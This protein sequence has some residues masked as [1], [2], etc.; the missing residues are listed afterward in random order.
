MKKVLMVV[1]SV[2]AAL[3][4]MIMVAG[5]GKSD[6]QVI[7]DG[8]SSELDQF[9]DVNSDQWQQNMSSLDSTL[10]GYGISST[11]LV[12]SWVE[13]FDYQIGDVTIDGDTATV[14]VTITCKQLYPVMSAATQTLMNDPD[15]STMSVT[16]LQTKVGTEIMKEFQNA[17]PVTTT[18]S[19]PCEKS[20]NSWTESAGAEAEYTKAL[21]GDMSS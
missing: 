7:K 5:C 18:I 21:Y 15:V 3:T 9:K 6:E 17:T 10:S 2:V 11:D 19:V 20:G 13:G 4:M 16:D 1:I 8:I 12:S 14:Q